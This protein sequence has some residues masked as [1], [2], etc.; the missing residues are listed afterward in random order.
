MNEEKKS[1]PPWSLYSEYKETEN[2][3]MIDRLID[4]MCGLSDGEKKK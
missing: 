2:R 3:Q 4:R 1:P